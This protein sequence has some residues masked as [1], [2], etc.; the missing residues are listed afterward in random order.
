MGI[1]V[2]SVSK[3]FS[4]T[5][6]LKDVSVSIEDG[7]F[8]TF[9][10]PLGAGKTTLLRIMCGI[11]RPD[12]G[13]I[14]YDGQDVTDI[15]VQKRPVAMVYQQFVNYPSMTLYENIASPL[16][17]SRRKYSKGE[18]EKRVHESA[19]LL[20]IRQILG[21]YPEEVSG[22]QKQ[23]AAIARALTK[24]AKFIFLDEPLANLDY[25][26]REEL[27]GELK[28]ILRRKGGVVVYATPEAV[29]ALS[30]ASHVGYIENGQLWQYG[31]LK[32]VYRYPQF[33]EVGRYFSYPTMNILP[34][35]VEKYA[36]GA[37]LVLS[38]DLRVDVSRIAD[39]L[40]QE[41]YQ[42]GIRAYNISTS[43]EHAE[44]VPFQAEVELSE[45][46]GSDTELHV[47]HNGQTLVV[48]LQE[49]ARHEIGQKV[50]LY[51]D[52]TRLFL[53]H[54]HTN[55][56]VLKTFQETTATSAAQEA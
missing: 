37:A 48:L 9:L 53:F 16:R 25:K 45:E 1:V 26:L 49:F 31:A 46:L 42:V 22:G 19:D 28:E 2:E 51:L 18:I 3:S 35:T 47:R 33:K 11:D 32:H 41:V 50:T 10:G 7:Q 36:K 56:L 15:A 12:S 52:S 6:A 4:G 20:G 8:V 23:R 54:P 34:G 29:D 27:R 17:V 55:E 5:F 39:Q 30:M 40:D 44:M 14:Y 24:D 43:K 13:R 38:D 21:H